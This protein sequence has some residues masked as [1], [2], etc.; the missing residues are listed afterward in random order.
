MTVR[1][2]LIAVSLMALT[3]AVKV[4]TNAGGD[5]GDINYLTFNGPMSLPGV[6][7]EPGTYI[8][9]RTVDHAEDFIRVFSPDRSR[10]Y[11][12]GW[13]KPIV[14]P[15]G[16]ASYRTVLT[17]ENQPDTPPQI[18]AWFPL[19]RQTGHEFIYAR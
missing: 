15:S 16:M 3:L 19:G 17:G 8:F 2:L 4:A 7:L 18:K 9:Q 13:S 5:E 14:R 12:S 1:Q 6:T 10:V 11:F